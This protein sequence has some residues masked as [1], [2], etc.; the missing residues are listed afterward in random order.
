[1]AK[2]AG[3]PAPV[4]DRA[5]AI[6][7]TLESEATSV[8]ADLPHPV[9][10]AAAQDAPSWACS[11]RRRGRPTVPDDALSAEV[12]ARLRAVDPDELTPRAAHDLV[13]ELRKE[14][15]AGLLAPL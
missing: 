6:L 4:I 10:P 9:T 14:V 13:R 2:L 8:R 12:A 3:L 7:R 15:D 11:P 5:R 1:M